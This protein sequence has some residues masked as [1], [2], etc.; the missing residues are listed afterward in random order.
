MILTVV[1]LM[2]QPFWEVHLISSRVKL[3]CTFVSD[4][5]LSATRPDFID[6]ALSWNIGGNTQVC[7]GF[8]ESFQEIDGFV[9]QVGHDDFHIL[10]IL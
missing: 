10:S 2:R 9:R 4:L 3:L 8:S 1:T 6:R 5:F 7:C